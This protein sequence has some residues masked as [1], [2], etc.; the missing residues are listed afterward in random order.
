M[1]AFRRYYASA[2]PYNLV[3]DGQETKA[4]FINVFYEKNS[5]DIMAIHGND[6]N[7]STL[8]EHL[9]STKLL[10]EELEYYLHKMKQKYDIIEL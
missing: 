8:E 6:P 1:D 7:N 5:V 10:I 9:Q 3:K 2:C 4:V